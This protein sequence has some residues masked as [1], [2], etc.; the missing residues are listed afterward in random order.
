MS[1][2]T[3]KRSRP[4]TRRWQPPGPEEQWSDSFY[5]GGGDGRGLAFYSRI[6]RR[7]NEGVTEGA[8]GIW[9]PG[10]GFL[11]SFA[12]ERPPSRRPDRAPARSRSSARCRCVLW[13]L[14]FD[15]DGPPVR[16]RRARRDRRA[17]PI[18]TVAR[19]GRAC[20]SPPGASR[21][22]SS[23]GLVGRWSR[24]PL[25]AARL[26]RRARSRSTGGAMPLAGSG[27]ARPLLGRARLA[28]RPVLALVR[29]GRRPRQLPDAQ[30]RRPRRTA[31]RRR[32]AS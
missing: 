22:R 25:R 31:A 5:F 10:Q 30:Q 29:H 11:L 16:A 27:H 1:T 13:E 2:S 32:A 19:G 17:T 18:A 26:A 23:P 21:S 15:G 6:G 9:L 4:R 12:R 3:P 14:R 7:P 28:G 24:A 20:A 8:L